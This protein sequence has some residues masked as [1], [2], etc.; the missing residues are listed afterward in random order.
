MHKILGLSTD[1]AF[2]LHSKE[3]VP[4]HVI[5]KVVFTYDPN[6]NKP[7]IKQTSLKLKQSPRQ[8]ELSELPVGIG[9]LSDCDSK[10]ERRTKL[11][12]VGNQVNTY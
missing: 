5:L 1:Y 9:L 12:E 6:P 2:C 4:Y 3:R 11:L 7:S 8:I 10:V